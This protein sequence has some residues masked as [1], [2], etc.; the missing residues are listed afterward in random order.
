MP[1]RRRTAT[2]STDKLALSANTR[3][4]AEG[5][6]N[7]IATAVPQAGAA[8]S[9]TSPSQVPSRTIT[10][11][12]EVTGGALSKL[13]IDFGQFDPQHQGHLPVELDFAE[14]GAGITAP[15]GAVAVNTQELAQL[16]GSLAG[17]LGG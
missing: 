4:I 7:D 3:T 5:F 15:S 12:A 14:G 11:S 8:L 13:G 2:G 10:M 17:G 1:T 9:Q 6:L 16:F